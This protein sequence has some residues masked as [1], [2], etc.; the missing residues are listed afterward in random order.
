MPL[1]ELNNVSKSYGDK[2]AEV[3]SGINL[4]VEEGEFVAIIGYSGAGKTTLISMLAGLVTPDTGEVTMQGKPITGPGPD[5]A[6][7]FQNYSLLPWLTVAQNVAL[8]VDRVFGTESAANRRDRVDKALAMVNLTAAAEKKPSELSGGMRQRVSVARALS[9]DPRVL[10]LD[11]PLGALDA[12]TRATIQDEI[13]SIWQRDRKTVL[14]ITNDVDEA[15]LLA[16]RIIPLSA[17]PAATLGPAVKVDIPRPRDRKAMNHDPRFKEIRQQ[18]IEWLLGEGSA[19]GRPARRLASVRGRTERP[20]ITVGFLPLTDCAPLAVAV[21]REVFHKHGIDVKLQKFPSWD[22]ITEAACSGR[23]D[24][25]HMLASIPVAI[26]AGLMGRKRH[27]LVVPWIMN[28]NGQGITLSSALQSSVGTDMGKLKATAAAARQKGDPLSFA[29]T[30]RFGTHEMWLRYWLA[31]GGIHPD[32][33]INLTVTPPPLMLASLR[34]GE[35]SGF[36][37]GE[38]WNAKAISEGL[39]YTA[40]ASQDVWADHPEK[41]LAFGENFVNEQPDTLKR[42]LAAMNEAS[43][44]I[45]DPQNKPE[46]AH[47]VGKREYCN[48]REEQILPRLRGQYDFGDGRTK[49]YAVH[50]IRFSTARVNYP[51][52][53]YA[54]WFLTQFRRWGQLAETPDYTTIAERVYRGDLYELIG[55]PTEFDP[56]QANT[57]VETLCDSKVFDPAFP[58][59]Y[60]T[61]F[62][63]SSV[64]S[65]LA[66]AV[67]A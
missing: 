21:E 36:C 12:L 2:G 53:K 59:D 8:A 62:E 42:C 49:N 63:I 15:I 64:A 33:D 4:T 27:P 39:G 6:M 13:T 19:T 61:G 28:R 26:A 45:D 17:G 34:Q 7:V 51:Q 65:A 31:A 5:R 43:A 1:L 16:D 47:I 52:T 23:I 9:M 29:A 60:A 55:R 18:V 14:L 37:V 54:I 38:P 30:H 57:T 66:D 58:E 32:R 67:P 35:M 10:L 11:E 44:W 50:P 46:T 24:A 41:V 48:V 20:T 3:L 40:A 25:A 22:A 56:I